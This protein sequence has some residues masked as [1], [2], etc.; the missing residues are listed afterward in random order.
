[1]SGNFGA[2][3]AALTLGGQ[4]IQYAIQLISL[5]VL[6]RVLS[7]AAFGVMAAVTSIVNIAST[8]GDFGL[9]MSALQAKELTHAQR[10]NLL[11]VNLGIGLVLCAALNLLAGPIAA[12]YDDPQLKL[13]CHVISIVFVLSG[14]GA[15]YRVGLNREG[16]FGQLALANIAGA[17]LALVVAIVG[18]L[19]GLGAMA[20]ALQQIV[21][22][23]VALVVV[24]AVQ[25]WAPS[26]PRRHSG[27]KALVT[28]GGTL[29][30]T[31]IVNSISSNVDA[32]ALKRYQPNDLVGAYNRSL[33]IARQPMTQL[34][35]PLSRLAVPRAVQAG[36]DSAT[37][38]EALK[39]VHYPVALAC[40]AALCLMVAIGGFLA[41]V[42]LGGQW[43][44]VGAMISVLAIASIIQAGQQLM[45]WTL[46]SSGKGRVLFLS[47]ILPRAIFIV[48]VIFAARWGVIAVCACIIAMQVLILA[49]DILWALPQIGVGRM[50]ALRAAVTPI[51]FF[52]VVAVG[53]EALKVIQAQTPLDVLPAD[54]LGLIVWVL[55]VVVA[56]GV[57]RRLRTT[58]FGYVKKIINSF[59]RPARLRPPRH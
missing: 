55:S 36:P 4:W 22:A 17:A 53:I 48:G 8:F 3:G 11:W 59:S 57:S 35:S 19:A 40:S 30:L 52:L 10:S 13:L 2:R 43:G 5:F 16:R 45:Y 1:M 15:Q 56:I 23:A 28:F 20:L 44:D 14:L 51:A 54:V 6:A 47:E 50:V 58:W 21:A 34:L 33:Q 9:S 49:F 32:L 42:V 25:P 12:F 38:M 46:L 29:F 37:Q 18:A 41:R 39:P 7:P 24:I 26:R 27:T 31:Y